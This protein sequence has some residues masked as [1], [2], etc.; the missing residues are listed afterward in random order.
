V[1][2]LRFEPKEPRD[3]A[4]AAC[5]NW[6][7]AYD[8]LTKLPAWLSDGLCRL[9]TGGGY[10]TR[11]LY[12]NDEETFLDATRPLVLTGIA[13]LTTRE[14]LVDRSLFLHQPYI[15]DEKRC[16]EK[17]FL[18]RFDAHAPGILGA[19]LDAVAG[20]LRELPSV[21][22]ARLPRMADFALFGEAVSRALGNPPEKFLDTYRQNRAAAHELI[23]EDS[24]VARA[25]RKL[26][27]R[28]NRWEGTATELLAEVKSI[29]A[30][31]PQATVNGQP[32]GDP[33]DQQVPGRPAA[34]KDG[35]L[36]KTGRGLSGDRPH[37]VGG[38]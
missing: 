31:A 25:I 28:S 27:E 8:N 2:L 9:S 24:V 35:D 22:L 3:L 12:T 21:K 26:M 5:S 29:V 11:S 4:I 20:A 15:S 14:D 37:R 38:G 23:L 7:L 10:A 17:E 30:P 16:T 32:P 13:D 1:S 19:L 6:L 18:E 36:P 33:W 34:K